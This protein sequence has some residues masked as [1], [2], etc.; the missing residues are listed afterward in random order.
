MYQMITPQT[1]IELWNDTIQNTM[2]FNMVWDISI[3]VSAIWMILI[4][5][6][7]VMSHIGSERKCHWDNIVGWG[8]VLLGY[9]SICCGLICT[10]YGFIWGCGWAL[11]KIA[12]N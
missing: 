7:N 5:I 10:V 6:Y 4:L 3:M 1:D 11:I 2:G 9:A 12:G 8:V